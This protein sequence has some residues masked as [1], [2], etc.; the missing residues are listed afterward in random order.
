MTTLRNILVV[1]TLLAAVFQSYDAYGQ[2]PEQLDSL[3]YEVLKIESKQERAEE[4]YGLAWNSLNLSPEK[5]KQFATEVLELT[6]TMDLRL[7]EA[8][9]YNCLG[10]AS[11]LLTDYISSKAYFDQAYQLFEL[12]G[13]KKGMTDVLGN[14]GYF[15]QHEGDY[16]KALAT[17]YNALALFEELNDTNGICNTRLQIGNIYM[18][19]DSYD[20]ALH[21]DSLALTCYES[22]GDEEGIA[23]CNGNMANVRVDLGQLD[24][25]ETGYKAAI[26]MFT[27]LGT[28]HHLARELG[29]LSTLYEKQKKLDLALETTLQALDIYEQN[30]YPYG[31]SIAIGNIG[32]YYLTAYQLTEDKD[33]S[34]QFPREDPDEYLRLAQENLQ[35]AYD[36]SS[37]TKEVVISQW[38]AERLSTVY[39]G[40]NRPE[41]ALFYYKISNEIQDSVYDQ[42]TK[43]QLEKLTTEREI[44]VRDKQIEL[45]RLAVQKKRNER[46]YFIIGIA[47][48]LMTLGLIYRNYQNQKASNAQLGVLNET[49]ESRNQSLNQ[50]LTELKET[51]EQ[52]IESERQKEKAEVRSRISQDI[53]DDISSGLTKINWLAEALKLAMGAKNTTKTEQLTDKIGDSARKTVSKLGEIVWSTSP[54]RDNVKSLTEYMK[55]HTAEFFN[56]SPM[57]WKMEFDVQDMNVEIDPEV[58]R[59]VFLVLKESLHNSFKYSEASTV[60]VHFKQSDDTFTLTIKDDGKGFV[61]GDVQGGGHGLHNMKNRMADIGASLEIESEVSSGTQIVAV[62]NISNGRE[63]AE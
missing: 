60:K 61:I 24:L 55:K 21:Y 5:S 53:H 28:P 33:T 52:L 7:L 47:L 10:A 23:I 11:I 59:N 49:L 22:I 18:E 14:L 15:H 46:I 45:D 39:E 62:G 31:A 36:I 34:A 8:R 40:L 63:N 58:R 9:S 27:K 41:D 16:E 32:S 43:V 48:L 6:K 3:Y 2:S 13:D 20:K 12:L 35:R 44:A 19:T 38:F 17:Q 26:D 56:N 1:L 4:L 37:A 57:D 50:T 30:N 29:N 42:E 54:E 51:Q 25:A